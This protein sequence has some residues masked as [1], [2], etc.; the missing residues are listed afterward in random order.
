MTALADRLVVTPL[1]DDDQVGP[2]SIDVR[3]GTEFIVFRRT[4]GG[5]IDPL[6]DG[7]SSMQLPTHERIDCPLGQSILLHHH[8]FVLAST[9]EY[10]RLPADLGAYLTGRTS[11]ARLG[12]VVGTSMLLQPGFT[13]CVTIELVN[14]GATPLALHPGMRI[15]QLSVHRMAGATDR[16]HRSRYVGATGPEVSKLYRD[17]FDYDHVS[18]TQDHLERRLLAGA[19]DHG[20]PLESG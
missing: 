6:Q 20:Q 13:G 12:L 5:V 9:L 2:A 18:A 3:L 4:R 17:R 14:E 8:Q 7:E 10:I 11:W 19:P 15:A 16:L 1:L